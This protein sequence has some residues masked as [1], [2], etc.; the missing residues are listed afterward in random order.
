M[1]VWCARVKSENLV[2]GHSGA[3]V[4]KKLDGI[5]SFADNCIQAIGIFAILRQ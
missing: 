5:A 1:R 3:L 2:E 4:V